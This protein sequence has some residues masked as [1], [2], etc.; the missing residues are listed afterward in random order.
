MAKSS[1]EQGGADVSFVMRL[2]PL[3]QYL[4]ADWPRR[5]RSL[6][7]IGCG[8]G[9]ILEIL[10]T[11]GFDVT[12]VER[13]P[14]ALRAA[15]ERLGG[16]CDIQAGAWDDVPYEDGAFDYVVLASVF[17]QAPADVDA[18]LAEAARVASRRVLLIF[19][20]SWSLA[21]VATRVSALLRKTQ[22][23]MPTYGPLAMMR[24]L[25]RA[26]PDGRLCT[27]SML[28]G[29]PGSWYTRSVW[30]HV[31]D[32]IVPLPLGAFVGMRLD[33]TPRA[34]TTGLP[35]RVKASRLTVPGASA[36]A[37]CDGARTNFLDPFTKT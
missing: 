23:Q 34:P 20:N 11:L 8:D 32:R 36:V 29:P 22:S 26:S 4:S 13:D 17:P 2:S 37:S 31:N 6:L 12:G 15:R 28:L 33:L 30:R 5:G 14:D 19:P 35:L 7:E 18:L 3:L 21:W 27:R 16:R 1:R 24:A 9:R 10:W 25:R